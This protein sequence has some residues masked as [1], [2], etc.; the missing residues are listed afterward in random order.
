MKKILLSLF[1]L[2]STLFYVGCSSDNSRYLDTSKSVQ[3][4]QITPGLY[5]L[6][7]GLSFS[8]TATAY[9]D[10]GSM[11]DV[12]DEVVW[13]SKQAN[14]LSVETG[15][16]NPGYAYAASVGEAKVVAT[17][18]TQHRDFISNTATITVTDAEL[19]N[20]VLSPVKTVVPKGIQVRYRAYGYFSDRSSFDITRL[21]IFQSSDSSVAVLSKSSGVAAI[22][23]SVGEGVTNITATFQGMSSNVAELEVTSA[24]MSSLQITPAQ[25]T[26]PTET[27]DNF[28]ATAYFSD[29]TSKDVTKQASWSSDDTSIVSIVPSGEDGGLASALK[30]GTVNITA[31]FD[32]KTSN[33]AV[34]TVVGKALTDIHLV[35]A[36][37]VEL[38]KGTTKTY[39]VWAYYDDS[40]AKDVTALSTLSIEDTSIATIETSGEFR[41]R[42]HAIEVG[43]TLVKAQY[44]GQTDTAP[45]KVTSAVMSSLQITPAQATVPTETVDNFTATAYFSDGT[46]K[47][48]TKQASWSSDDT[49][50]VSIVPSGEDGGLASALKHG[51]VN[52]TATFDGKTSNTAV[53]TVVG[54]ALTDI[55]LVPAYTV[56]LPK[57][58][59][60][61]YKVWAYYD[62]STAKDVT[63]LSTLSIED[64][65]IATIETSGEFR[66][67]VHAI[68]VGDT[69]VKAQYKGQTDT[70]PL[71]VTSPNLQSIKIIPEGN[72]IVPVD[73]QD[74]FRAMAYYSDGTN[75]DITE[76]ATWNSSESEIVSIVPSGVDGGLAY[77]ISSGDANITATY[78]SKTSDS[79]SVTV[80]G[81]TIKYVQIVPN[82]ETIFEGEEK[83]YRVFVVYD[84]Y[85]QKDVSDQVRIQSLQ[86]NIAIADCK[87]IIHGVLEGTAELSVTFEGVKSAREFVHIIP[88]PIAYTIEIVPSSV[89]VPHN[90]EGNFQAI[91]HNSDGRQEDITNSVTW[92]SSDNNI[93]DINAT[94]YAKADSNNTGLATITATDGTISADANVTVTAKSV[95]NIQI[96]PNNM[97]ITVN[98]TLKYEVSVIYDDY[99]I[100]EV[101]PFTTLESLGP[102]YA[103]F[104]THDTLIGKKAGAAELK[105]TWFGFISERE[106]IHITE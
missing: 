29:G 69:L 94:G 47:D 45:L 82:N 51:T 5:S 61:T 46:S 79:T 102:N 3:Q 55:H 52:I 48:V 67:R 58:T 50:I 63:A 64:T 106:F 104:I 105:A 31:T 87:N 30:H 38:P 85:T 71:K 1:L 28:T 57:G 2:V 20:I 40:T 54:K 75:K 33:T 97:S 49:S 19:E 84:D 35:P 76:Y 32:G 90:A 86:P 18:T 4:I 98:E 77:A 93:V 66:G 7:K 103:D 74:N 13:E 92:S 15:L 36:Y 80:E 89:S 42:V 17:L 39:K 44:K 65:S 11:M 43:D 9:F 12:T 60:K 99:T 41:G 59:T 91:K 83:Q 100:E 78:K 53:I 101:T 56:E 73:T 62:D 8:F 6:P 27:V 10:D 88:Q 24:V 14:V 95:K 26:V 16:N 21:A 81:K 72:I 70:A 68:E 37:T 23:D 34:I 96:T 25:A 22:V